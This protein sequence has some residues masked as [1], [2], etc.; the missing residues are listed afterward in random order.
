MSSLTVKT[1]HGFIN[2]T[3]TIFY[4]HGYKVLSNYSEKDI[5][6][7]YLRKKIFHALVREIILAVDN[8]YYVSVANRYAMQIID[9]LSNCSKLLSFMDN[10][11]MNEN[12]RNSICSD[13]VNRRFNRISD[14]IQVNCIDGGHDTLYSLGNHIVKNRIRNQ[15]KDNS[16]M[17]RLEIGVVLNSLMPFMI[18]AYKIKINTRAKSVFS[19]LMNELFLELHIT[20]YN[21]R[22]Y[23]EAKDGSIKYTRDIEHVLVSLLALKLVSYKDYREIV[24]DVL[25]CENIG[26]IVSEINSA[27]IT[28]KLPS[29]HDIGLMSLEK[30]Y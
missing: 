4:R 18:E 24:K 10:F 9:G 7:S 6:I 23:K 22:L 16:E 27:I 11:I 17:K 1:S 30:Y 2:E 19:R 14:T 3:A 20:K 29:F 8:G 21:G 25:D 28:T 12:F 13:V 26:I 5:N 15:T